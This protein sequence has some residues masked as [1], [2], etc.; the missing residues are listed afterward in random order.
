MQSLKLRIEKLE[1]RIAPSAS[2]AAGFG[3]G[4]GFIIYGTATDDTWGSGHSGS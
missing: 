1:G 2:A 3:F 4:F